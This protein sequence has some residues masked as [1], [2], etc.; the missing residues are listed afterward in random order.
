MYDLLMVLGGG[1]CEEIEADT[2]IVPDR[3][4]FAV[5]LIHDI[6]WRSTLFLGA[7]RDGSAVAVT[8][9]DHKHGVAL[10]AVVAGENV[11]RQIRS[12][13]LADMQRS[14]GVR[15]GD[16]DQDALGQLG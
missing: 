2:Q 3:Q 16:A 10:G 5:K 15:P 8:A 6:G 13:N 14:I 11:G 9:G 7:N 1:L 12:R 4:E